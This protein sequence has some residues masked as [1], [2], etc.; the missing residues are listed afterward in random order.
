MSFIF[1]DEDKENSKNFDY[2]FTDED[3]KE[4]IEKDGENPSDVF[5]N[6]NELNE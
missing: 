1:T 2:D 6:A 5:D 4:L 3:S